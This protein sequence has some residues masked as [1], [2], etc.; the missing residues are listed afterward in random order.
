MEKIVR[1]FILVFGDHLLQVSRYFNVQNKT[2]VKEE[3]IL[4]VSLDIKEECAM[5]V[6]EMHLMEKY[7]EK[8]ERFHAKYVQ[9]LESKLFKQ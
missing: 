8:V 6:I 7:M 4:N 5:N 9:I 2:R 1:W 3:F